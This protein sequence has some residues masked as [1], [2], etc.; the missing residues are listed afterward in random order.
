MADHQSELEE[1]DREAIRKNVWGT[2]DFS[3]YLGG[4]TDMY[5][6]KLIELLIKM[7]GGDKAD[8]N[9]PSNTPMTFGA[10]LKEEEE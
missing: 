2:L 1:D 5:L 7:L 3:R 10:T 9:L 6:S 4:F 8:T